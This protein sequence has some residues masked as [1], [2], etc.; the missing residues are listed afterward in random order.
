MSRIL[1]VDNEPDLVEGLRVSLQ[2]QGHHL[3][4][5]LDGWEALELVTGKAPDVVITDWKMPR[6]D[7][8]QLCRL[9]RQNQSCIGMPIIV[10]SGE[11]SPSDSRSLLYDAYLRKPVVVEE[12]LG[13][14]ATFALRPARRPRAGREL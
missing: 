10:M 4:T 9:L 13:I 3:L 6:L 2:T 8:L 14:V 5:A 1:L 11:P 7:G 12:V